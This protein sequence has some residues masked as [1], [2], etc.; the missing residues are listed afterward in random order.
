[1]DDLISAY[2]KHSKVLSGAEVVKFYEARGVAIDKERMEE[3]V[4][5]IKAYRKKLKQLLAVPLVKQKTAEWYEMR[6]G[7]ITASDFAQALGE[8]KFGTQRQLI[9][10]KVRPGED[11]FKSNPFFEW[12]NLFEQVACDIYS[13]MHGVKMYEFGLLRHS[14]H[15]FFGAS[16]DG[17]SNLGIMLEIKCPMKRKITGE[18]PMQYYYQIQGQLDVCGL[19]ECDYFECE[20]VRWE[21]YA[22]YVGAD[23]AGYVEG[24]YTGWI[25]VTVDVETGEKK[26]EYG[27]V[28]TTRVAEVSG[29]FGG[30][31]Y[32]WML[33]KHNEQ[34]VVRDDDFL[35]KNM[36]KLEEVWGRILHYRQNEDAYVK[37]IVQKITLNTQCFHG[38]EGNIP[39]V[40]L[41]EGM[42]I[43]ALE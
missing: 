7:L 12:G 24:K 17:I 15:S 4:G 8:G 18:V 42:K 3:R 39:R 28:G 27:P 19:R 33:V 43:V 20:L 9:E 16:P 40:E 41:G 31:V 11:S 10:K 23:G 35:A 22:D 30:K 21:K 26:T 34:R 2:L 32:Y 36:P 29:S 14:K 25:R 13:H 38:D 37:D 5:E 6:Q 1:M